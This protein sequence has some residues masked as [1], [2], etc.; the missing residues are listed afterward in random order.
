MYQN[1]LKK[2]QNFVLTAFDQADCSKL[3]YHSLDHSLEVVNTVTTIAQKL[4]LSIEEQALIQIAA[5]LHD[6]GYL[7]AYDHHEDRSISIAKENWKKWGL[8]DKD[9]EVVST[10][11]EATKLGTKAKHKLAALLAD[12]DLFYGVGANFFER[13]PLLRKEWEVCKKQF[14]TDPDWEILQLNFLKNLE[15][16]SQYAQQYFSP[17]V[18]ENLK[19]QQKRVDILPK[20]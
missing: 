2:V 3:F 17:I 13:G 19:K 7:Q 16:E 5:Y 12:A 20:D 18:Q 8:R 10:A 15:F 6:V 11:I 14:Y 1:A 9:F 4:E